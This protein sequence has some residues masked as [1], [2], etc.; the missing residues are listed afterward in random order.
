ME[1]ELKYVDLVEQ[2]ISM[3]PKKFALWLFMVTV[4]MIFAAMTSAYIVR[5]S[6]GNWLE[7][8]LPQIFW[9]TS[10]IVIL[11]SVFLQY[12]Y[13]SAKKDNMTG[14]KIGLSG[15]VILGIAFLIGQWYSWVALVDEEVFFV[16]NPSGSFLYVFTGLHAIHLISGVIFLII[17][18]I[19]SFSFQIHSKSMVRMEMATTY[20]HFL[21]GLWLYLF[22]FLLLNH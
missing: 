6:E 7:Y 2:P 13:I 16:G 4:V 21:G 15:A 5:Q 10:G 11:S 22:M 17:V 20:W 9:F 18:L 14:L 19:S 12:G 3:H 1:Q 8:D